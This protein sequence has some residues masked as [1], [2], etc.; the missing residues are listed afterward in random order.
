MCPPQ[1]G[2]HTPFTSARCHRAP[3]GRRTEPVST[4]APSEPGSEGRA[5]WQG[6]GSGHRSASRTPD[7]RARPGGR[8]L[9]AAAQIGVTRPTL[10]RS[11]GPAPPIPAVEGSDRALLRAPARPLGWGGGWLRATSARGGC[12]SGSQLPTMVWRRGA[13][14]VPR[15][16]WATAGG[17]RALHLGSPGPART[18]G[19][20]DGRL[21]LAAT[22]SPQLAAP[23]EAGSRGIAGRP[24]P[25][26]LDR[27]GAL[28]AESHSWAEAPG[29]R[30]GLP[31]PERQLRRKLR[32]EATASET[33]GGTRS[34]QQPELLWLLRSS[35]A[36]W[37]D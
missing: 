37:W 31:P 36:S 3:R 13:G 23:E 19:S 22:N 20:R 25:P 4:P 8:Q 10:G 32:A 15:P 2:A 16:P 34:E 24:P 29:R 33:A 26:P 1:L 7:S 11:L 5:P 6:S 14:R 35:K 28:R 17:G 30:R 18:Q 21:V 12:G 9:P 27:E